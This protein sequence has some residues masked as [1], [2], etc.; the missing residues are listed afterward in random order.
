MRQLTYLAFAALALA[1]IVAAAEGGSDSLDTER[2]LIEKGSVCVDGISLTVVEPEE[3]RFRVAVI[4]LTLE[5]TS[6]GV[7]RE[8]APEADDGEVAQ[9]PKEMA[10]QGAWPVTLSYFDPSEGSGELLPVYEL[11]FLLY[12]NGISRR[13][14]MGYGDFSIVGKMT[15]LELLD[16]PACSRNQ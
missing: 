5:L 13:I 14:S 7:A 4:P 10:E 9:L 15:E 1:P 12:E 6:L 3:R 16:L 11:S 2:Y 8:G